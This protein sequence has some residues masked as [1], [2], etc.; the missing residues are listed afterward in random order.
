[1]WLHHPVVIN[2]CTFMGSVYQKQEIVFVCRYLYVV[3]LY[4]IPFEKCVRE[5]IVNKQHEPDYIPGKIINNK[6]STTED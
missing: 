3:V 1:M 2:C 4:C 5:G 6:E